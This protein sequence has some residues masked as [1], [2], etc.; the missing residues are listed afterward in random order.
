MQNVFFGGGEGGGGGKQGV[1][2]E[3]ESSEFCISVLVL[4][5][6]GHV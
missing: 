3:W 4:L 6:P 1:S 2:W 5:H